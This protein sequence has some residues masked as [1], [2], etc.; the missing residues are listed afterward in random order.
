LRSC[1]PASFRET[2]LSFFDRTAAH[3]LADAPRVNIRGFVVFLAHF[4]IS[5]TEPVHSS[6]KFCGRL[7]EIS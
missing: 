3:W 1:A 4:A 2:P 5:E 6:P 7:R